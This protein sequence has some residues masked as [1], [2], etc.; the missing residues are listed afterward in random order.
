M[1]NGS[2]ISNPSPPLSHLGT[3]LLAALATVLLTIASLLLLS[4]IGGWFESAWPARMLVLLG[5]AGFVT[6]MVLRQRSCGNRGPQDGADLASRRVSRSVQRACQLAGIAE[7]GAG[8]IEGPEPRLE[9]IGLPP[10]SAK[11]VVNRELVERLPDDRELDV[12]VCREIGRAVHFDGLVSTVLWGPAYLLRGLAELVRTATRPRTAEAPMLRQLQ[13]GGLPA[14]AGAIF[15]AALVAYLVVVACQLTTMT[16]ACCTLLVAGLWILTVVLR[17]RELMADRYAAEVGGPEALAGTLIR[18]ASAEP[19]GLWPLYQRLGLGGDAADLS[20]TQALECLRSQP[21]SPS[22]TERV[23][24]WFL[25]A[26]PLVL[27]L[28]RLSWPEPKGGKLEELAESALRRI[29]SWAG[30]LSPACRAQRA[31]PLDREV[32]TCVVGALVGALVGLAA[33]FLLT[34]DSWLAALGVALPAGLMLGAGV[35][36]VLQRRGPFLGADLV[37]AAV[38]AF[39]MWLVVAVGLSDA[40]LAPGVQ[41]NMVEKGQ[42]HLAAPWAGPPAADLQRDTAEKSEMPAAGSP[43]GLLAPGWRGVRKSSWFVALISLAAS[44]AGYVALAP[45]WKPGGTADLLDGSTAGS[46]PGRSGEAADGWP[47]ADETSPGFGVPVLSSDA[48]SDASCLPELFPDEPAADAGPPVPG[49]ETAP[50][51]DA[52]DS[53][54]DESGGAEPGAAESDAETPDESLDAEFLD[55][56]KKKWSS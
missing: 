9:L 32:A 49:P 8:I 28:M 48:P 31:K 40:L 29:E 34:R 51:A 2:G 54:A 53:S 55:E 24:T 41:R 22:W 44:L 35:A 45:A 11:V 38:T 37:D 20:A 30:W 19:R 18:L 21:P 42:E 56:I 23:M 3:K 17:Q 1:M 6:W 7:L 25:P 4:Q 36:V 52:A 46:Q 27:R 5:G 33:P 50:T 15:L 14:L 26:P 47:A 13:R 12:L 16:V 39:S 10:R 43:D